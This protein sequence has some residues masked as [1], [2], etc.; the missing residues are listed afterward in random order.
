MQLSFRSLPIKT[1][2]KA[3]ANIC[4]GLPSACDSELKLPQGETIKV[5]EQPG[6][7]MIEYGKDKQCHTYRLADKGTTTEVK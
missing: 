5:T 6:A 1:E 7:V 2:S 4:L 3:P